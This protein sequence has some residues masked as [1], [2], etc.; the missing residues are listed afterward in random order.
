MKFLRLFATAGPDGIVRFEFPAQAGKR[1]EVAVAY[2]E[3]END[4][5]VIRVPTPEELGHDPAFL[6]NVIGS[7]DDP[8][9]GRH[10]EADRKQPG[11]LG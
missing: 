10:L 8:E 3:E 7:I 2:G 1:Y 5:G 9:F 6:E 4:E 11:P